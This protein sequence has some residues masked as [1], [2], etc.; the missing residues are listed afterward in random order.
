MASASFHASDASATIRVAQ[1][2]G[3]V[4]VPGLV[5]GLIGPLGA[6]K[7]TFVRGL[8]EG[9]QNPNPRGVT[10]P[11][12]MLVHEYPGRLPLFHFDT[13][14]LANADALLDLGFDE[15]VAS[16]GVCVIEWADRVRDILPADRLEIAIDG[17]ALAERDLRV[18]AG[19]PLS[20]RVLDDWR[21]AAHSSWIDDR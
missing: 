13:Y 11:T 20:E 16:G 9:L 8:A 21:A 14:R 15:Y 3:A 19:G 7:T 17:A 12:F 4:A 2:L 5:I 10:S 18:D 1:S 6:G